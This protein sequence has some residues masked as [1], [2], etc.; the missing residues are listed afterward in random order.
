MGCDHRAV[1]GVRDDEGVLGDA[2]LVQLVHQVPDERVTTVVK[3]SP[4]SDRATVVFCGIGMNA[5]HVRPVG[6]V[7]RAFRLG[8]AADEVVRALLA[9][10][11]IAM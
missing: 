7:E 2:E 11:S 9:L 1:V 8:V 10:G 4:S 3:P 6:G 5:G